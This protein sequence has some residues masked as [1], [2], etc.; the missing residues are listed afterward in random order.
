M[1]DLKG[2]KIGAI[3]PKTAQVLGRNGD[4]P[5]SDA[6]RLQEW[7]EKV[8]VACIGPITAN[9]AKENGLSVSLMPSESTIKN[10]SRAIVP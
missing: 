8:A 4:K 5:G 3:G 1:R 7:M 2:I 10:L 6:G 9:T